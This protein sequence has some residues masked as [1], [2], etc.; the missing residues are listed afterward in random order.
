MSTLRHAMPGVDARQ[1]PAALASVE[2][3]LAAQ[4]LSVPLARRFAIDTLTGWNLG[5][6]GEDVRTVVSELAANAVREGQASGRGELLVR[7]SRTERLLFVQVGDHNPAPPPEPSPIAR[8]SQREHGRGL[9]IVAALSWRLGWYED[10]HGWKL[11]WAA[12]AIPAAAQE[13]G[14]ERPGGRGRAA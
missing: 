3:V 8:D 11:V 12:F 4:P 14:T 6:L 5:A 1:R 2:R 13:A 10:G 9:A 7:L